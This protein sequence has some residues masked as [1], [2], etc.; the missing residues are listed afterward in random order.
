MLGSSKLYGVAGVSVCVSDCV[1]S[2]MKYD[3]C[4]YSVPSMSH[5]KNVDVTMVHVTQKN[6]RFPETEASTPRSNGSRTT[7]L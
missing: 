1:C 6:Q 5:P 4:V 7:F 2:S 3:R